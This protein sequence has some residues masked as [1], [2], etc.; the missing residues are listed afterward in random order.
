MH[1]P[2]QTASQIAPPDAWQ[3]VQERRGVLVDVREQHE[4]DAGHAPGAIHVPLGELSGR[5]SELPEGRQLLMVCR[6]GNRSGQAADAL[7]QAG[8][9]AVNVAGGMSVWATHRLPLD[10]P[11]GHIA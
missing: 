6:S 10:P 8:H 7:V 1:K 11:A 5:L 4:W 2:T 3:Q 9:D